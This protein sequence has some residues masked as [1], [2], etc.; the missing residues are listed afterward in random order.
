MKPNILFIHTDE[1]RADSLGAYSSWA[2]TPVLDQIAQEGTVFVNNFCQSPVCMPSR[3]STFACKPALE[4][5]CLNNHPLHTEGFPPGTVTFPEV[6]AEH[7][8]A[9]ASFGK[10][11]VFQHKIWQK[12]GGCSAC[13]PCMTHFE[14]DPPH[15]E[16]EHKLLFRKT[17]LPLISAGIFPDNQTDCAKFCVEHG[18]DFV[19]S[20]PKDQPWLLRLSIEWPHTPVLCPRPFDELY[21]KGFFN[22]KRQSQEGKASR[23]LQDKKV[24]KFQNFD[25]FTA[26]ELEWI[27]RCYYGLCAYVDSQIGRMIEYLKEKG[28][29]DNTII[30]FG[31]DHGRML[32]EW[33]AGE[34]DVFDAPSWQTALIMKHRGVIPAGVKRED[35]SENID[36]GTTLLSLCGL[37]EFIPEDYRGVDLF[38][39]DTGREATFGAIKGAHLEDKPDTFRYAVRT[40]RYR[41]DVDFDIY[42]KEMSFEEYDGSLYDLEKDPDEEFNLFYQPEHRQTAEKLIGMLFDEYRKT[43]IDP[44]L[45]NPEYF[46]FHRTWEEVCK[47]KIPERKF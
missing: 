6:F 21:P 35:L 24:A 47:M 31:S 23:S 7:G 17:S 26:E 9:T 13:Y 27:Y 39:G 29:Y 40:K 46:R 45:L 25:A 32:G 41:L 22:V 28:L 18:M 37:R 42:G 10:H 15:D 44:R 16:K 8:Y 38:A 20:V 2:K 36:I 33:G 12:A 5:G 34:K 30:V 3:S 1:Q 11:H 43:D 4:V 14:L 19:E